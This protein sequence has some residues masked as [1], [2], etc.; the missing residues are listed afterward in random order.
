M[1]TKDLKAEIMKL[2]PEQRAALAEMIIL[3]LEEPSKTEN[4]RLWLAEA[5]RRLTEMREGHVSEIPAE[6]VLRRAKSAI[7]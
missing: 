2:S 4:E 1:K 7:S 3:S 6:E 5:E